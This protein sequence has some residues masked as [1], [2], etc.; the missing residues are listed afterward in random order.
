MSFNIV[1]QNN[2]SEQNKLDKTLAT[3]TTLSGELKSGTSILDPVFLV[4]GNLSDFSNCNY[5]TISTFNRSYFINN[6]KSIRTNLI[7]LSCHVDVLSTYKTAIRNNMAICKR[8]ENN[9]NL[10]LNDGSFKVYQNPMVLTKLF[11]SGFT[12]PQFVLAVAGS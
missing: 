3:I 10:Y 12:S 2:R 8:Q 4:E 1:I 7:E 6:I 5:C 11:P 9:W